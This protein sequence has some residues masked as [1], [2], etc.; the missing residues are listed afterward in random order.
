MF[1][2][3]VRM[4]QVTSLLLIISAIIYQ[5]CNAKRVHLASNRNSTKVQVNNSCAPG[6]SGNP[7]KCDASD[8]KGMRC[9][10]DRAYLTGDYWFGRCKNGVLCTGKCPLGFCTYNGSTDRQL[11]GSMSELDDY[12]CGS[13]RTGV[14]CGECRGNHSVSYHSSEC[15]S[16]N[17]C[18]YGP[19]LYIVSELIPLTVMFIIIIAFN[20]SFTSGAVNG[21]IFFAQ[22]QDWLA[23]HP[24]LVF[25]R[26]WYAMIYRFVY[27]FF[28]FNF[29]GIEE[30]SFCLWRG[31]TVLD[32]MAFK[33]V[34]FTY[35]LLLVFLCVCV[36]NSPRV[37][38]C[39]PCL[40]PNT[41]CM[42]STLIHGLTAFF[43]M[44]YS[45][46]ASVTFSILRSTSLFTKD[47]RFL[48]TVVFVNGQLS[49]FGPKH[50]KYALPALFFGSTILILPPIVLISYPLLCKILAQCNLSESEPVNCLARFVPMQLMDSFQSC[51]RNKVR[52]FAGLFFVYRLIT[53][54]IWSFGLGYDNFRVIYG[55]LTVM[56]ILILALHAAVQP[57][58]QRIHNV[59]DVVVF[60]DLGTIC[61]LSL[62]DFQPRSVSGIQLALFY[63]PLVCLLSLGLFR[64]L[65]AVVRCCKTK[66][67][68]GQET[69]PL[70]LTESS[71]LPPLR[72][73]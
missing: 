38:R 4:K 16:D 21:F 64:V 52:F 50:L 60:A 29:F 58:K 7:C 12:M 37:K 69:N 40:R 65:K 48:R 71:D 35:A 46:C 23:T 36:M 66:C 25:Q 67:R 2:I 10:K 57:C 26:S 24:D 45:Q 68:S 31:A 19:L 43:V 47:Y 22:V 3:S 42:R 59:M 27:Q 1:I 8:Y 70:L 61:A 6:F 11:P 13:T 17:G 39:F 18:K 62:F 63:L 73:E 5:P 44:C 51:F 41:T 34:T 56:F 15:A 72:E 55:S 30:L 14:L 9:Y 54:V 49:M 53:Q 28:N 32:A 20:I 33:Y